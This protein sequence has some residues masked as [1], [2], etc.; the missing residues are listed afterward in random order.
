MRS[1]PRSAPLMIDHVIG[2]VNVTITRWLDQTRL[3]G[4]APERPRPTT[5][6]DLP[7]L[8]PD[9][10]PRP[11]TGADL[12]PLRPDQRPRPTTGADLPR[13]SRNQ[14]RGFVRTQP[15]AVAQLVRECGTGAPVAFGS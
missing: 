3:P 1:P 4:G 11:T 6:A 12:P 7:P 9:Q 15:A 14:R 5:G 10:R 13:P 2:V 8:R